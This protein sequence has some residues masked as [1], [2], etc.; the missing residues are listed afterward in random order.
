MKKLF[1]QTLTLIVLLTSCKKTNENKTEHYAINTPNT[2]IE[3]KGYLLSGYF[4]KGTFSVDGSDLRVKDGQVTGGSFSIP[5]SSINVVNLDGPPKEQLE[6]HLKS[7]DFF[8][9][10]LHPTASFKITAVEPYSATGQDAVSGANYLIT[11]RFTLLGVTKSISFPGRIIVAANTLQAEAMFTINRVDYGMS[12]AADP[13]LGEHHI[14]PT[15]DIH[16]NITA[17]KQ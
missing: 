10:L 12:Y 4:N 3:W 6:S 5:I 9:I 16:L 1:I 11:G 17:T 15:V 8:N 7:Q 14:L 2:A 13:A